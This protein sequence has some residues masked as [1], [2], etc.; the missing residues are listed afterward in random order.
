MALLRGAHR[1]GHWCRPRSLAGIPVTQIEDPL[2]ARVLQFGPQT[3]AA[4]CDLAQTKRRSGL[5]LGRH[6]LA[7]PLLYQCTQSGALARS[8]LASIAQQR[9]GNIERRFHRGNTDGSADMGSNIECRGHRCKAPFCQ[10]RAPPREGVVTA[11]TRIAGHRKL[12]WWR[13]CRGS[14]RVSCGCGINPAEI[15]S[16]RRLTAA[17]RAPNLGLHRCPPRPLMVNPSGQSGRVCPGRPR[18]KNDDRR[19]R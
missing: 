8:D 16:R 9:I 14:L 19:R 17:K 13:A 2:P 11:A 15:G 12:V 4:K 3:G 10:H 7:Q 1:R 6:D 5:C 18:D